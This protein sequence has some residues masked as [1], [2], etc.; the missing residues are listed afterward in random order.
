M[1]EQ[2]SEQ[3]KIYMIVGLLLVAG[4]V[5]YFRFIHKSAPR[6]AEDNLATVAAAPLDVPKVE[7]RAIQNSRKNIVTTNE[8]LRTSI[9]DIFAP[10]I[11]SPKKVKNRPMRP[12]RPRPEFSTPKLSKPPSNLK[13]MGVIFG[14]G[15]PVA[16][17]NG[18]FVRTG[19]RI[20]KYKVVRI[21]EKEVLLRSG[22]KT[23]ELKLLTK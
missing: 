11:G 20:D 13:L 15:D 18:Q 6:G 2:K 4:I 1:G 8:P 23:A 10:L 7:K 19:E 22:N 3:I 9:R 16:I 14:G 5:A 21:G 17:I 12:R